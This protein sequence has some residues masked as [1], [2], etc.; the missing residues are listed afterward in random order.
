MNIAFD[1][2][3]VIFPIED[4]QIEEGM[5]YFHIQ[6]IPNI[7]GYDIKEV[8]ECSEKEEIKFWLKKSFKYNNSVVATEGIKELIFK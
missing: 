6:N 1:M 3:G 7:N 5:K 8:F 2:D 4:F